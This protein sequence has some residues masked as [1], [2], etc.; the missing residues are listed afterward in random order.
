[1]RLGASSKYDTAAVRALRILTPLDYR[2][3]PWKNG[4][5]STLEI[6]TDAGEA[7]APW[8]WRLS[9]ADVPARAPFSSFPGIDRHIV[10]LEGDGLMLDRGAERI[11]VPRDGTAFA[12]AGEDA[13]IGE[14]VGSAVR[15]ANL[16]LDRGRWLGTLEILRIGDPRAIAI[17][18]GLALVHVHGHAQSVEFRTGGESST[19]DADSTLVCSGPVVIAAAQATIVVARIARR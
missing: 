5:G 10:L 4:L 1:M 19:L 14:P 15:D 13:I 3:L 12:F 17:D 16:M 6:V 7:G 8:S 9:L 18:S 2:R 11:T